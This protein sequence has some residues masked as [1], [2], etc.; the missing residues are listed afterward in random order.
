MCAIVVLVN[1]S[2][3]INIP[4]VKKCGVF[5]LGFQIYTKNENFEKDCPMTIHVLFGI[6]QVSSV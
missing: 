1:K 5:Q 3:F 2:I 4:L 6:I